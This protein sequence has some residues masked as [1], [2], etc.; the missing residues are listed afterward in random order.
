M[1]VV[2]TALATFESFSSKTFILLVKGDVQLISSYTQPLCNVFQHLNILQFSSDICRDLESVE[3]K[4]VLE[5]L[6]T[7][8][9]FVIC[10]TYKTV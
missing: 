2:G 9:D 1:S 5:K 3:S 4:L 10:G 6:L 7:D 8:G